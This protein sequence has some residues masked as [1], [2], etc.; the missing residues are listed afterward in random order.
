MTG[1]HVRDASVSA[2]SQGKIVIAFELTDEGTRIF[3]DFTA[4]HI[5]E[6]VAIVLD[7]RVV[8]APVIQNPIADGR[9]TISGNFSLTTA[10]NIAVKMKY[11]AL[12]IPLRVI[13]ARP[14]G[15]TLLSPAPPTTRSR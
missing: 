4:T 11:D 14:V 2:D 12:P 6:S 8:S 7:K 1:Q 15:P 9:G 10:R 3:R 13:D 5:G